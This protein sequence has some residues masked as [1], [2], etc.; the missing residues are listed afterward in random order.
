MR[1]YR[2]CSLVLVAL[3]LAM[4][5]NADLGIYLGPKATQLERC[6]AADL[7]RYL[8]VLLDKTARIQTVDAVPRDAE[9]VVL[10]TP[11]SLPDAGAPWPFNLEPPRLDGYILHS[12]RDD[13]RLVVVA[14]A[15]PNGVQNGVYGLLEALGFGFYLSRDTYPDE[16]AEL[17][18]F[19]EST[20]P[21]F[22]VRGTLPW[23]NFPNSPATWEFADYKALIDQL[24]RMRCNFVGFYAGD[25]MPYA[26]Y[27]WE[28]ALVGGGP[29]PN[30]ARP[31]AGFH[32]LATDRF[33]AGTGRYFAGSVFGAEASLID[34]RAASIDAAKGVLR[35]ALEY[36]KARGLKTCL[37]FEV[38]GDALDP[39]TQARFEARLKSL[40]AD[41]PTLDYVSLWEGE[42]QALWPHYE[43]K[44]RTLWDSYTQRWQDA[45]SG[46][47]DA[48][49]CAEAARLSLFALR[50][51]C[52][53]QAVRPDVGLVVSGWGGDAW[54]RCTDFFPGMDQVLPDDVTLSALDNMPATA[55][56]SAAYGALSSQRQRWP[57]VWFE[58]DADQ[59]MPQS[60]LYALA[61][62]CRDARAKGCQGFLGIHWRTRDVDAPAT[63]SARFS[64][65]PE[66]T[67]EEFCLRRARDLFGAELG[68][69]IAP[70]LLRLERLGYRWA[71]EQTDEQALPFGL[72]PSS[73]ERRAEL[74]RLAYDLRE[75]LRGLGLIGKIMP[76]LMPGVVPELVPNVVPDLT[77]ELKEKLLPGRIRADKRAALENLVRYID[78]VLALDEAA[79]ALRPDSGLDDLIA[80]G[81]TEQVLRRIR[82]SRL[83]DAM[84]SYARYM[85]TKGDLG[86]L[87][88]MNTEIWGGLRERTGLD[89]EA[90][91]PLELLPRDY[92]EEPQL[93]VLPDRLIVVDLP[94]ARIKARV[95]A[96][97]LGKRRF[98]DQ[99][100]EAVG[101]T[102]FALDFPEGVRGVENIEYGFEV[103]VPGRKTLVW[104]PDFPVRTA[105]ATRLALSVPGPEAPPAPKA[106]EPV[107]ASWRVLPERYSVELTWE[108]RPGEVYTVSRDDTVLG[109]VTDG[110]FEDLA[111][112]SASTIQYAITGRSLITGDTATRFVKAAVPELP[113]PEPPETVR[114]TTRANRV[115]LGWDSDSLLAAQYYIVKLNEARDVIEETYVDAD[116]GQYL[117]ISDQ[118]SGGQVY[119]YTIAGVTPDGRTGPASR[120]VG[121]VSST[122]PLEPLVFL[123]FEDEAFLEGLAQLAEN[124]LALGG[125]GWAEL[126]PQP[127][128]NPD[129]ALTLNLWLNLDDLEGM[130]VLVC[131]GAW[132]QSGY[133]LQIYN[134]QVRFFM[135]GVDTLDAGRPQPG[136]W[137][138]ITATYG[139]GQMRIYIDG[140]LV[141][142]KRVIGRPTP[143]GYP[144]LFGRYVLADD[145]YFVRGLM[146]DVAVYD[147]PLTPDEVK[148]LYETG[149]RQ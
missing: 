91:A 95:K 101:D 49:R 12:V 76:T 128:W 102:T 86:V 88:T 144:L 53:I 42:G 105:V 82:E 7:Q 26:A 35:H 114:A 124:S 3:A 58:S 85:G 67:V 6:A 22:A 129:H 84:H 89:E 142:R 11:E 141:G 36:A 47:P 145:V 140:E 112:T 104:P 115:V 117:Q 56:V 10:G 94:P 83:A 38:D 44:P 34:D 9:G 116:Y 92:D 17:P 149:K 119:S 90:L 29:L 24:V 110:W 64:W 72:R 133:F 5:A 39:G 65:N 16:E 57:V 106:I 87:A 69:A 122:D 100:L 143:S 43:A 134:G 40:L 33:F 28:G 60:N 19:H 52:L 55:T 146:D 147:V 37:G 135:A 32:P 14:G 54:L 96:R 18:A 79:A 30:T 46:V 25:A 121:V 99:P 21:A 139:F 66:L 127:E 4:S 148:E 62:A 137:Q 136:S 118:V 23:H 74:V 31:A 71:S 132:L 138:M 41:Y 97:P 20:S 8:Y 68:E 1:M 81:R 98:A 2:T 120:E 111:P 70:A 130:P 77:S 75:T 59:W 131:K 50:A 27:E 51:H 15:V 48:R 78:Y 80:G 63:Y 113:L 45:F 73:Q 108:A 93:L 13:N 126:P 107:E 61:G 103:H 125:Q 109:A 123:S